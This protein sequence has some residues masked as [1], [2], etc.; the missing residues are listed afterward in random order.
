MSRDP[1]G[2]AR[3]AVGIIA[4]ATSVVTLN[5]CHQRS[6]VRDETSVTARR[7]PGVDLVPTRSGGFHV[8]ILSGLVGSGEPLYVI[9]GNP[10][11]IDSR[12]GIDWFKP[13]DIVRIS[14]LKSPGD[15]AVYGPR[16]VNGVILITTRQGT[17][18]RL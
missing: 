6:P 14:V 13:E 16:G 1:L 10:M 8:R 12:R 11:A 5:G 4:C 17:T 2:T 7:F 3:R 15:L 18:P 9:D